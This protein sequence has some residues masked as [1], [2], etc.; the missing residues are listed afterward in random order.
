MKTSNEVILITRYPDLVDFLKEVGIIG[1]HQKIKVME[2][3]RIEDIIDKHVIGGLKLPYFMKGVMASQTF[4]KFQ[5]PM[6]LKGKVL[7]N[8]QRKKY[9]RGSATYE[10]MQVASSKYDYEKDSLN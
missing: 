6:H 4:L 7:T 3:V 9:F 5:I 2:H 1:K 10:L 8:E